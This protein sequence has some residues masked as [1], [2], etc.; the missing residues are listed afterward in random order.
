MVKR[1]MK[2]FVSRIITARGLFIVNGCMLVASCSFQSTQLNA[3]SGLWQKHL[4]GPEGIAEESFFWWDFKYAGTTYQ[5]F[6]L[7]WKGKTALTDGRRWIVVLNGSS[8]KLVRDLIARRDVNF[9][10][11]RQL[12]GSDANDKSA[13]RE[14]WQV[15]EQQQGGSL[16]DSNRFQ[17]IVEISSAAIGKKSFSSIERM[18][19]DDPRFD[20]QQ[21]R[22]VILCAKDDSEEMIE[23]SLVEMD[24]RGE[25]TKIMQA[26]GGYSIELFRSNEPVSLER[27]KQFLN[28]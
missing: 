27:L 18:Y 11:S 7:D 22:R 23:F 10:F 16:D 25:T 20:F 3:L 15:N 4:Y 12:V 5:L 14:G 13:T 19:C 26:G 8:V 21:F 9:S 1:S 28:S 2:K 6:P 24:Q 17:K